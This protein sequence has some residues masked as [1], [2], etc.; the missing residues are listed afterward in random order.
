MY[1]I[2][3]PKTYQLLR[4]VKNGY[5][6]DASYATER[7]AKAQL[8]KLS[9]GLRPKINADEWKVISMAEY[10]EVEPMVEVISIGSGK[11]VQ[12]RLSERGG[13]TD[14]ST[15]RYWTM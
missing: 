12:I 3:N 10:R 1:T 8:T 13:C 6:Q 9:T 11:P 5:W 4:V 2:Y 14:P 15:E 7:A